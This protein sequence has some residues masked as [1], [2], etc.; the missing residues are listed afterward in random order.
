[1]GRINPRIY[2]TKRLFILVW[3]HDKERIRLWPNT[4]DKVEHAMQRVG[5]EELLEVDL[6]LLGGAEGVSGECATSLVILGQ[7]LLAPVNSGLFK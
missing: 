6:N 4:E 3:N 7:P 2:S 5:E 1:M